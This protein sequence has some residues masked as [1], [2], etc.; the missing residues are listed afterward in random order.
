MTDSL[1]EMAEQMSYFD[2][3][4]LSMAFILNSETVLGAVALCLSLS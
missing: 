3:E 1:M 4:C 2:R